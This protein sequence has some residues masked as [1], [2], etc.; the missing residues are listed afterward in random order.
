MHQ[1]WIFREVFLHRLTFLNNNFHLFYVEYHPSSQF[2]IKILTLSLPLIAQY[3]SQISPKSTPQLLVQL[4]LAFPFNKR[5]LRLTIS[6]CR[7]WSSTW[8]RSWL[9]VSLWAERKGVP[10]MGFIWPDL[11]CLTAETPSISCW[12]NDY[13]RQ[14][15]NKI[16]LSFTTKWTKL[17]PTLTDLESKQLVEGMISNWQD[18]GIQIWEK[19]RCMFV[20]KL[21]CETRW[22]L[23]IRV[24][25]SQ[26]PQT[27]TVFHGEEVLAKIRWVQ[28]LLTP[29]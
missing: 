28:S 1:I 29:L 24:P 26:D 21:V 18:R 23:P 12:R 7:V 4:L 10:N 2:W 9:T 25:C 14:K 6:I 11:D 3:S 20:W 15:V 22:T 27:Q 8:K 13:K 19:V 16:G 5:M 17:L